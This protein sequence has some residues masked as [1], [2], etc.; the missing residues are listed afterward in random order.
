MLVF[1]KTVAIV[2][3]VNFFNLGVV[4]MFLLMG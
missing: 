3:A 4:K 2:I 1:P